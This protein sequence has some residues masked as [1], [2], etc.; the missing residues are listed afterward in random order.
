MEEDWEV[1]PGETR[2]E[3]RKRGR[4]RKENGRS[5]H[6][7]IRLNEDEERMLEHYLNKTGGSINDVIKTCLKRT[8][9]RDKLD[10]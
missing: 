2:D 4:P 5:Y 6:H 3:K 8:Y 10:L 7:S 1:G 9:F